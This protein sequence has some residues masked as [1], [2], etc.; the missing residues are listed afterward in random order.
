MPTPLPSSP[1]DHA[2]VAPSMRGYKG[3]RAEYGSPPPAAVGATGESTATWVT[4][5]ARPT[6]LSFDALIMPA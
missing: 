1:S 6:V 4:F 5:S 2:V 3:A